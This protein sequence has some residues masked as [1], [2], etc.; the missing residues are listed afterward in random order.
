MGARKRKA[1][2]WLSYLC[3]YGFPGEYSHTPT[4]RSERPLEEFEI[5][6]IR[7]VGKY[8]GI[9]GLGANGH[10]THPVR[11]VRPLIRQFMPRK[12]RLGLIAKLVSYLERGGSSVPLMPGSWRPGRLDVPLDP[13]AL[14]VAA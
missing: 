7:F 11:G 12:I 13:H 4:G 6:E 3:S 5:S 14:L 10:N 8:K 2:V 1:V 9:A